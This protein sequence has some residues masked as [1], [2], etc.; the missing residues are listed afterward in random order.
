MTGPAELTTAVGAALLATNAGNPKDYPR[1]P[2][3]LT[4]M[5]MLTVVRWR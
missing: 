1:M 5:S 3:T 2:N 4:G